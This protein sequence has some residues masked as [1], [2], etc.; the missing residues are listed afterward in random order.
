MSQSRDL[1]AAVEEEGR[2][3][4]VCTAFAVSSGSLVRRG[5]GL[6]G[7][8]VSVWA[9]LRGG[10]PRSHSCGRAPGASLASAHCF[11]VRLSRRRRRAFGCS[12]L[13]TAGR[14][15]TPL[16]KPHQDGAQRRHHRGHDAC[17]R[18]ARTAHAADRCVAPP[19][20]SRAQCLR[21]FAAQGGAPGL[22]SGGG[23]L[24]V[25]RNVR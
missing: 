22:G 5:T 9:Q 12:V 6:G 18:R 17:R 7:R 2:R 21:R 4:S 20:H 19:P 1:A 8:S 16:L 3:S 25:P 13:A 11:G 15:L 14:V 24:A 10:S 23:G